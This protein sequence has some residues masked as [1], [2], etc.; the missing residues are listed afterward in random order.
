M[1]SMREYKQKASRLSD[2]LPWGLLVAPGVVLLKDGSLMACWAY[3]GQDI[4]SSEPEQLV[5]R[6]AHA[7][8]ALRRLGQ[9][10]AIQVEASRFESQS[11]PVSQWPDPVSLLVDEERRRSFQ[12]AGAQFE[13]RYILTLTHAPADKDASSGGIMASLWR[14]VDR[15]FYERD[16]AGPAQTEEQVSFNEQLERFEDHVRSVVGLLVPIFASCHRLQTEEL[17]TYLHSTVSSKRHRVRLPEVP[18]YLDALLPDEP[19]DVG[20]ELKL[21]PNYMRTLTIQG[22]PSTTVPAL[23]D[24]INRLSIEYRW[25]TRAIFMDKAAAEAMLVKYQ[26]QFVSQRQGLM[27]MVAETMG[28]G[29]S[30]IQN[31]DALRRAQEVAHT[32]L[33]V[34]ADHVGLAFVTVTVTVWGKTRDEADER[35]HRVEELLG[36]RGYTTVR[37]TTGA[38]H[39][40]LSSHPGNMWA[41]V[42]LPVLQT[43]TLAHMLPLSAVW[44]GEATQTHLGGPAHVWVKTQGG[45]P[46]R[47]ST[48]VGDVGHTLILGPTGAGK[49]TLLALLALQWLRYPGARVVAFDKGGSLKAS[50]L[51]V[52]GTHYHPGRQSLALQPLAHVDDTSERTWAAEWLADLFTREGVVVDAQVKQHIHQALNALCSLKQ[53]ERTITALWGL[54]ADHKLRQAISHYVVGEGALGELLD[55]EKED[56]DVLATG[57]FVTFEMESLIADQPAALPAFLSYLF[58]RLEQSFDGKPTLLILDEAWLFLDHPAFSA[59]IREWLKVLRKRRVY[60]VFASQSLADAMDSV[61]APTLLEA[62]QTRLFLPNERAAIPEIKSYYKRLGLNERQIQILS[63]ARPKRDYYYQ[64]S[65]GSRLFELGLGPLQL[66]F[67]AAASPEDL[68]RIDELMLSG[69]EHFAV[70][71]LRARGMR[72]EALEVAAMLQQAKQPGNYEL[73]QLEWS[74][75]VADVPRHLGAHHA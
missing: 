50:T 33:A 37:E 43:L 18:I 66:A 47:L 40:W 29:A 59:R 19:L 34:S 53:S 67:C 21:G 9:G 20:L 7:N 73:E 39:A 5:A 64:S 17:L 74:K 70:A 42:R 41:H 30:A 35:A 13:S 6:C 8:N 12:D 25:M 75:T 32:R 27:S 58:H 3:R 23:L 60:V 26:R 16:Q 63:Q 15:L 4:D 11:Y 10:W 69:N 24:G 71:W 65:L 28:M 31:D 61:I 46:F 55:G 68:R 49:S 56:L 1:W 51:A 2:Y 52:G 72:R 14:L 44:S 57:G 48:N 54:I 22:F 62:C 45:T 36:A 38:L